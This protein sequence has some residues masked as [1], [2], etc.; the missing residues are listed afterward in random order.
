MGEQSFGIVHRQRQRRRAAGWWA[1]TFTTS[2]GRKAVATI[3]RRASQAQSTTSRTDTSVPSTNV[4]RVAPP[5]TSRTLQ[6]S[7]IRERT[8]PTWRVSKNVKGSL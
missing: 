4:A 6:A 7:L 1:A 5:T 2:T 3:A 8:S